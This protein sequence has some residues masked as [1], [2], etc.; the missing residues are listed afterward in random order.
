MASPIPERRN[1]YR[2]NLS[3]FELFLLNAYNIIPN[4]QSNAKIM[5]K[6]KSI[7]LL[8]I[9]PQNLLSI[10]PNIGTKKPPEKPIIE[11]IRIILLLRIC[12]FSICFNIIFNNKSTLKNTF[13][14]YQLILKTS[15]FSIVFKDFIKKNYIL[16]L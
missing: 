15:V 9:S 14:G 7:Q 10:V 3:S 13:G 6:T 5:K 11:I 8:I 12:F 4:R 16:N 2:L 1:A